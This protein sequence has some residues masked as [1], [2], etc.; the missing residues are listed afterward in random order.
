[1]RT[2][3]CCSKTNP[4]SLRSST[5]SPETLFIAMPNTSSSPSLWLV[6]EHF[7]NPYKPWIDTQIAGLIKRGV[8]IS[9]Y[10]FGGWTTVLN[11]VVAEHKLEERTKYLPATTRAALRSIPD[12][13]KSVLRAPLLSARRVAVATRHGGSLSSRPALLSRALSFPADP[14]DAVLVHDLIPA[15]RMPFLRDIFPDTRLCLSY[16][17]GEVANMARV[18][19]ARSVF[20]R[21]DRILALSNFARTEAINRGAPADRAWVLPLGFD[22]SRFHGEASRPYRLDGRLRLVSIGRLSP[23][24]GIRFAVKAMSILKDKGYQNIHYT[25][26]GSGLDL[27]SL[28]QEASTLG[29][30]DMVTFLGELPSQEIPAVLR[31]SDALILPSLE[32]ETW[33]ETQATVV[34]E[35]LLMGCL[36][37]TTPTGALTETNAPDMHRFFFPPAD[38]ASLA[39]V[40]EKLSALSAQDFRDLGASG[41]RFAEERYD[42]RMTVN[43]LYDHLFQK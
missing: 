4:L 7:P 20:S 23:E 19:D 11:D 17:G 35:A 1:M 6:T 14:P 33:A 25:I 38:E 16:N 27:E 40:I 37:A 30:A 2:E 12:P 31:A 41:R 26:V 21:F 10:A 3:P 22:L 18:R 43:A 39:G 8:R 36:T 42:A 34:Q 15:N 9:I 29:I 5:R 24:K 32:T 28:K 13:L